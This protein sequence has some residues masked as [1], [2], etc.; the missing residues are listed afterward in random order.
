MN[1]QAGVYQITF[2]SSEKR[3][4]GSAVNLTNRQ[5]S[6]KSYLMR[7][8]HGNAHLQNAFNKYGAGEYRFDVLIICDPTN[9]LLYEQMAMDAFTPERLYNIRPKAESNLGLTFSEEVRNKVRVT[10]T[11]RKHTA[12]ARAKISAAHLGMTQ[13]PEARAKMSIAKR[14]MSEETKDKIR[15]ARARQEFTDESREKLSGS[16]KKAWAEGRRD[17]KRPIVTQETRLKLSQSSTGR[18]HTPE[19]ILKIG[20]ASASRIRT[21]EWREKMSKGIK[22]AWARRKEVTQ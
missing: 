1:K 9:C 5:K 16:L 3:Y 2:T 20:V 7:G 17:K 22:A 14:N 10:S 12:E 19:A 8:I 15:E 6:H 21:P 13:S 11:G 4:I 18:K